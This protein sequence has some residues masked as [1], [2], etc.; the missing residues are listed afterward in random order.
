MKQK[1]LALHFEQKLNFK[2]KKSTMSY[3]LINASKKIVKVDNV[4]KLNN[5][6]RDVMYPDLEKCLIMWCYQKILF[7]PFKSDLSM[8]KKAQ[9]FSFM[10]L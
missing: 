10:L 3:I 7:I 9:E 4:E 5:R 8:T 2:V 6:I 1:T